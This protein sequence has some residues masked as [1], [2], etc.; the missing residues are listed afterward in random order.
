MGISKWRPIHTP[1]GRTLAEAVGPTKAK[2]RAEITSVT[3]GVPEGNQISLS[4][5]LSSIFMSLNSLDSKISPHSLHSTN[6]ESSVRRTICTGG[7][8]QRGFISRIW[9]EAV[10][11][12]INPGGLPRSMGV[13][14]KFHGILDPVC[15]L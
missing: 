1:P 8:L 13:S 4:W 2:A 14:P 12:V 15:Q 9:G 10:F 6:S 3:R 11:E 7:G 5:A